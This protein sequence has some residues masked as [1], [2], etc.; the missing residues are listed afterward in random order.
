MDDM[1]ICIS[2]AGESP[3]RSFTLS[4]VH[5]LSVS[6]DEGGPGPKSKWILDDY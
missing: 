4:P 3:H 6:H 1:R 2:V 5:P